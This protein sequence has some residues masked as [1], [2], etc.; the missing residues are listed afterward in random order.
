MAHPFPDLYTDEP[1][2]KRVQ[3]IYFEA[4]PTLPVWHGALRQ[5]AYDAGCLGGPGVVTEAV[6]NRCYL[7]AY[8]GPSPWPPP[9]PP[10]LPV[11]SLVLAGPRLQADHRGAA[12]APAEGGEALRG[13]QWTVVRGGLGRGQQA[14]DC[15]L[16]AV[17][18]RRGAQAD[19]PR[20][21]DPEPPRLYWRRLLWPHAA[22][23]ADSA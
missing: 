10:P 1:A 3:A 22:A 15:V 9:R 11:P 2:A 16:P 23:G 14:R 8:I 20:L 17:D 18:R 19:D 5:Q 21:D 6:D 4:C 7:P 13:D 12:D